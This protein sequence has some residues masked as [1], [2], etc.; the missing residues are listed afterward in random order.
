MLLRNL[1]LKDFN[2]RYARKLEILA[3]EKQIRRV[4]YLYSITN[5]RI[6]K[7]LAMK[8]HYLRRRAPY[9]KTSKILARRAEIV[10]N[11]FHRAKAYLEKAKREIVLNSP[12]AKWAKTRTAL[13]RLRLSEYHK[14]LRILGRRGYK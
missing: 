13:V 2:K 5:E 3:V 11:T 8:R 10:N 9:L 6:A 14:L 1:K 7:I 4:H 12:K